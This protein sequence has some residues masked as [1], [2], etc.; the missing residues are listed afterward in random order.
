MPKQHEEGSSG[1]ARGGGVRAGGFFGSDVMFLAW[2]RPRKRRGI[3]RRPRRRPF[4]RALLLL[5]LLAAAFS[6][7]Y[8]ATDWLRAPRPLAGDQQALVRAAAAE[9]RLEPEFVFAV[10]AAESK[11][12]PTA[13]S[14]ADA[15]GLMQ[16]LP[17]TAEYVAGKCRL[18]YD[19]ADDLY[20][21]AVNIRLGCAY[22]AMLERQFGPD[23]RLILAAY[24]WG[25]GNVSKQQRENPRR[26]SIEM[27]RD[28]AP[29][30]TRAYVDRVMAAYQRG[31]AAAAGEGGAPA[32]AGGSADG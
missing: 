16:L 31:S 23:K 8:A 14:S 25:P 30:E 12:D 19:G 10:I 6:A 24:N 21:P 4:A 13:R 28:R 7:A 2:H 9:F 26:S 1:A 15:R 29:E 11:G 18:P 32:A 22:L 27:I 17:R 3:G 5:A 20:D